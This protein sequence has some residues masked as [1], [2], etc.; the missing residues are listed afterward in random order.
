MT[1]TILADAY[2][3]IVESMEQC[4]LFGTPASGV[5]TSVDCD[6]DES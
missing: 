3:D 5:I 4:R 6:M 2:D 1:I